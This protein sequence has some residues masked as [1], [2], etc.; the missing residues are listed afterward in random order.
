MKRP[1][2]NDRNVGID[3]G[4]SLDVAIIGAGVSG[5]YAGWR[6]LA[7]EKRP[8]KVHIFELSERIGGR[9]ESVVLP[10]MQIAGE[11]G[12]MRYM[13][14]HQIV[15]S[16]ISQSDKLLNFKLNPVDFPM[17]DKE[18]ER[19]FFYMRAQRPFRANAWAEAQRAGKKFVTRYFLRDDSVGYSA[20]QLF[21]KIVYDV[22]MQDPWFRDNPKYRGLVSRDSHDPYSYTFKLS[23]RD[24][25]DIKPK[26]TYRFAG[27]YN[28]MRVNDMGFWNL[29]RDR[30][31][32]E[33]YEFLAVAG[34]YFSN[35]INW[36]AA[37]A[38]PYMV[39]DFSNAATSY[40]TLEGGYDLI[41]YA[42]AHAFR[43]RPGSDIW[44][45]NRLLDFQKGASGPRKYSLK[46]YNEASK[47]TW[48]VHADAIILALPRRSLELLDQ[49]NFFFDPETQQDRQA[50]IGSTIMEPALKILMGFESPWW[51]N[52][53][54]AHAGESITDL[55]M[56]Q[57]YYFGKDPTDSHSMF[58]AAY[59]DMRTVSFW[60]PLEAQHMRHVKWKPRAT[61]LAS[62]SE[63]D[64]LAEFQAPA[65]MIHEAMQQVRELHGIANIPDPYV[66][67]YRNWGEDPYG[68]GYHA[69][70]AGVDVGATMRYMRRPDP[71][72]AI[73][74]CGEAYSDQQGWVEGALCEAEKMLQESF[75]LPWPKDWLDP[76]YYLGW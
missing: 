47:Q 31:G 49:F 72:E 52:D 38:F 76:K 45:K 58:L 28:G 9:L 7:S 23:A 68:G 39:G 25:D 30:E 51:T 5:L 46:I 16:L 73:H 64:A 3:P 74:V 8:Q 50:K 17:G 37:E 41:A 65:V 55:P 18:S 57:C 61:K 69:W 1:V 2:L 48:T 27:P 6:L 33:A 24:W 70:K 20:D 12:G 21:N 34:G 66:T 13:T 10:G 15:T 53:F 14:S 63:L 62:Q 40:K 60:S 36:N 54:G 71:A 42:L 11:L 56:R 4:V 22:L 29:I 59:N 67:W 43:S 26:L 75:G 44:F 35:T 32:S 19:H